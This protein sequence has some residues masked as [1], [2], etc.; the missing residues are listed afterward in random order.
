MQPQA[1]RLLTII[2]INCYLSVLLTNT[3][4]TSFEAQCSP[5]E[6]GHRHNYK[7]GGTNIT[8]SEVRRKILEVVPPTYDILGIQQLQRDIRRA[9][10]GGA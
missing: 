5:A 9:N 1:E 10:R 4:E 6:Q 8:A 3:F 2:K 7:S